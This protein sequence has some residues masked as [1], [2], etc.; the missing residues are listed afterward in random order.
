VVERDAEVRE[1]L[2]QLALILIADAANQIS[3]GVFRIEPDRFA[4]IDGVVV[5]VLV[6]IS[7]TAVVEGNRVLR[8]EPERLVVICD[9]A[10]VVAVSLVGEA[11]GRRSF[12]SSALGREGRMRP[13]RAAGDR[14]GRTRPGC[15]PAPSYG[16]VRNRRAFVKTAADLRVEPRQPPRA[17]QW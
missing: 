12:T 10:I 14:A 8:I 16:V 4:V 17:C 11:A 13:P 6:F 1:R 9:G 5:V 15:R 3:L 2:F 7:D